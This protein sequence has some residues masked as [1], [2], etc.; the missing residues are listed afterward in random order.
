MIHKDHQIQNLI[1][2]YEENGFVFSL[3]SKTTKD[4]YCFEKVIPGYINPMEIRVNIYKEN[5]DFFTVVFNTDLDDSYYYDDYFTITKEIVNPV[6]IQSRVESVVN[7]IKLFS[8]RDFHLLSNRNHRDG[9]E[10]LNKNKGKAV[11]CTISSGLFYFST[12]ERLTSSL[13][14]QIFLEHNCSSIFDD[15][16]TKFLGEEINE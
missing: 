6:F 15:F 11:F 10:V 9:F 16:L 1:P 4:R 7:L 14:T 13:Y 2:L 3:E 8:R 12:K 5:F